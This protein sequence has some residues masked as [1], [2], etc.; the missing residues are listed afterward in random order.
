MLYK[1]VL[2]IPRATIVLYYH[3]TILNLCGALLF[4]RL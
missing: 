2:D 1:R 4:K 3:R